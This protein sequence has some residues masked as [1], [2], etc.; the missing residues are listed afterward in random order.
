M[1]LDLTRALNWS[2]PAGA[3]R[4][5]VIDAHTA[6]EPLRIVID[7]TPELEGSTV[8]EKRRWAQQQADRYRTALMWEPRGHA[9]MYGCWIGPPERE[10]SDFSIVF[11]HNAGYSTMCGHGI[12]AAATVVVE[13]GMLPHGNARA[14]VVPMRIDSPAGRIEAEAVLAPDGRVMSARFTNVPSFVTARGRT[15]Q[16]D[17][18]GDV[19]YDLAFGGAYYAFVDA[20][21]VGL[22]CTP[23]RADDLIRAGRRIKAAVRA[24]HPIDHPGDAEL[25][26]LYGVIFTGPPADPGCHSRHVCIFADGEVDRSPTG[27]GVSARIALLDDGGDPSGRAGAGDES[28]RIESIIGSTFDVHIAGRTIVEGTRAVIPVVEGRAY[29]TGRSEF[30]LD[31][32]DPYSDGFILR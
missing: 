4:I 9:D 2:P 27:T 19:T 26:F 17:P 5:R 30:I 24:A 22:S 29:I 18:Y 8:L 16:V 23:E 25:G 11:M 31:P 10:D 21:S 7:G 15:V 32:R 1:K 28:I 3:E 13:T 14:D 6:G 20:S 12:L